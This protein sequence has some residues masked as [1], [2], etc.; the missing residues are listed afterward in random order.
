MLSL[1]LTTFVTVKYTLTIMTK[2]IKL[3]TSKILMITCRQIT[4]DKVQT[5]V[6]SLT[7]NVQQHEQK[8]C[9][10]MKISNKIRL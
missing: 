3:K 8:V 10:E 4:T 9:R 7:S 6:K 5:T 1:L 2:V